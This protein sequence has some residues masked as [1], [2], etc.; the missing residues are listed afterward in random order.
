MVSLVSAG[1]G[2]GFASQGT[3]DF[4][5]GNFQL[6]KMRGGDFRI[7]IRV[8]WNTEDPTAVRDDII[9][10]PLTAQATQTACKRTFAVSASCCG[11]A[12]AS[13]KA[14]D[15]F[16]I[17]SKRGKSRNPNRSSKRSK[18]AL[19]LR[20][21]IGWPMRPSSPRH[22]RFM[23]ANAATAVVYCG[24]NAWFEGEEVE[25]RRFARLFRRL[26]N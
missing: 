8:A 12:Q 19:N 16:K 15:H 3:K 22:T 6:R 17:L 9:Y 13:G 20:I 1:L 23:A 24:L 2:I 21:T 14:G 18:Q 25:F 26:G 10:R 4:A 11:A 7:G 5:N